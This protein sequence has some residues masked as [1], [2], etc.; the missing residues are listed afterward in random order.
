MG[1]MF[2]RSQIMQAHKEDGNWHAAFK[3]ISEDEAKLI[4]TRPE[5]IASSWYGVLNYGGDQG[6][7]LSGKNAV[8]CGSEESWTT[9]M[10]TGIIEEGVFPQKDNEAMITKSAKTMLGLQIGDQITVDTP[11]GTSLQ[12]TIS[13]FLKNVSKTME[14][15]SYGIFLTTNEFRSIYPG[16]T[17][18]EPAD[19][20][21][22]YYVQFSTHCNIKKRLMI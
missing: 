15:D 5:V 16:V 9:Q 1:D 2:I 3:S 10:Q 13:G 18:G 17:N 6:Y 7:T 22:V 12:F 19:Y 11:D 20:N 14:E 8:I 4:S 21:S